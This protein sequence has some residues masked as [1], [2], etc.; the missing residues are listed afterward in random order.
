MPIRP[1]FSIFYN[2]PR[3]VRETRPG[4]VETWEQVGFAV[5]HMIVGRFFGQQRLEGMLYG[6]V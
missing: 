2:F 4:A 3:R 5:L 1:D 6:F